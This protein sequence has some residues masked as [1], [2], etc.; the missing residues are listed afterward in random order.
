MENYTLIE[1]P[2]LMNKA[3]IELKQRILRVTII[4][5]ASWMK[6][7]SETLVGDSV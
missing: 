6:E 5:V 2:I 4:A 7:S 3:K 1:C